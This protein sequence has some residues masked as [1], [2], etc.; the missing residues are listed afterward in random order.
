[1][2]T[3][4]LNPEKIFEL[5]RDH[6]NIENL[7]EV[8]GLPAYPIWAAVVCTQDRLITNLI[9]RAG[10]KKHRNVVF[11][12]DTRCKRVMLSSETLRV[13]FPSPPEDELDSVFQLHLYSDLTTPCSQPTGPARGLNMLGMDYLKKFN[14]S[15]VFG[16]NHAEFQ[17][18]KVPYPKLAKNNTK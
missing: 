14:L 8:T 4:D 5:G 13:F 7:S 16:C 6:L 2:V 10:N 17:L 3:S 9:V 11:V 15:V 1:M 12:V 18:L